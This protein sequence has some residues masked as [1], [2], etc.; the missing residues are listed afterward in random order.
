MTNTYA[1]INSDNI[2]TNIIEWDGQGGLFDD[3][4]KYKLED[5]DFVGPGYIATK[6]GKKWI[7]TEP[8]DISVG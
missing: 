7:F 4:Q 8:G 5:G 1:L 6:N 2:V 3:F